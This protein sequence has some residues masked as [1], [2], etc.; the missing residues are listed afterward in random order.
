L[1]YVID[2]GTANNSKLPIAASYFDYLGTSKYSPFQLKE[3]FYKIG[4]SYSVSAG[5]DQTTISISGLNE[6]FDKAMHLMEEVIADPQPNDEALDNLVSDILK[7]RADDKLSRD[8]ILWGAMFSYGKYGPKSPY[9]NILSEKELRGLKSAELINVI[10]E[11]PSYNHKVLYYGPLS[12]SDVSQKIEQYHKVPAAG[13]KTAQTPVNYE[14]LPTNSDIVYV[15]NYPDMVQAEILM[16][17]KKEKYNEKLIPYISLYNEYFGG[18]MSGIVFQELRESKALAYSSF[19]SFTT[20][21][22]Y[23]RSHY[24]IAYI[25]TQADK[26]PEAMIGLTTLLNDMPES[27]LTYSSAR[28]N[29]IQKYNTERITKSGIL[30]A[31]LA[32]Q[33]LGIDHDIRKDIYDEALNMTLDDI[34]KFQEKNVK[35]SKY[36]ILVL[37]DKNKLDIKTLEKY[38]K[39]K[40]LTLEEIFGY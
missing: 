40:F 19:S 31:Y 7:V 33:K 13:L 16:I 23:D 28:N 18:G 8:K 21:Q 11:L 1:S 10:K 38:G 22:K 35:G 25:G 15:V 12:A 39:V 6:N 34:K 5:E 36:T 24:N 29:V 20:P 14:E 27:E 37:G 26:L 3:E 17:S 32:S 2:I 9:T 4:C 30:S